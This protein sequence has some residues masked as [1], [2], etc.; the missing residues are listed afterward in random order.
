MVL[1]DH[2]ANFAVGVHQGNPIDAD[3][4]NLVKSQRESGV[5]DDV[6]VPL[7]GSLLPGKSDLHGSARF[8]G[9]TVYEEIAFQSLSS[10][11]V[12]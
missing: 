5:V 3:K 10:T 6:Q 4:I 12:T 1:F 11:A 9:G 8:Q 7:G 2:R